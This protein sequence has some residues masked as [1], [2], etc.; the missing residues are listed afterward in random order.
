MSR[1]SPE[2]TVLAFAFEARSLVADLNAALAEVF[3]PVGLTCVQAEALLALADLGTATLK[4]LGSHLVAE[5]GHPSRLVSRLVADGLVTREP[6][7]TDA[8]AVSLALTDHGRVLAEAARAA[9]APLIEEVARAYGGRVS[10]GASLIR[11][12]RGHLSLPV[13]PPTGRNER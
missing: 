5:S 9:R 12:L 11:E 6:S 13:H 2:Q 1:M 7:R 10:E 8:R 4:Q 3:R